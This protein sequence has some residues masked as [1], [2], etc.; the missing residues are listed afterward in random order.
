MADNYGSDDD[1]PGDGDN[2]NDVEEGY[3]DNSQES[4]DY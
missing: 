3:S 2:Y 1:I 4:V